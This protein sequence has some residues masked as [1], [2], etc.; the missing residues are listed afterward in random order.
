MLIESN[1]PTYMWI[2]VVN[3]S[4]YLTNRNAFQVNNKL[5]SKQV[6]IGIP[7]KLD[8]LRIF[9][10]LTYVYITKSKRTKLDPKSIRCMF[11]RYDES[12]KLY[13]CFNFIVRR[14]II[15]KDVMFAKWKRGPRSLQQVIEIKGEALMPIS[16]KLHDST[17][18]PQRLEDLPH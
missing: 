2:E 6:Y 1:V 5:S 16:L 18:M 13:Y 12:S 4:T 7:L 10:C 9:G 14:I 15:T 3:T 17:N 8:H 11:T